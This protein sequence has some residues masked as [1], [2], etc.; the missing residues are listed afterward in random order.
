MVETA[1]RRILITGG[2]GALGSVSARVLADAGA[3]VAV[4]DVL[5]PDE[6][7]ARVGDPR[8]AYIEADSST[9]KGVATLVEAT[10]GALGTPT[11]VVLMAAV[12][13]PGGLLDQTAEDIEATLRVNVTAALLTA[14]A[15]VRQWV[16]LGVTGNLVFVSSWVQDVP[17]PGIAPYSASKAAL[18]SVARSFARE[19]AAK[20]IRANILAP[21]IVGTGMAKHQW[22]T[23]PDYRRRAARAIP[24][25]S[26]Q[27]P[28]SVADALVFLCSPMSSYMTGSTLLIDGGASLYPLDPDEVADGPAD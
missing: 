14:Q 27:T 26:L 18:R 22:D 23:E 28:Q 24:L 8:V 16:D 11:D 1:G 20:G 12:V 4:S 5:A 15:F 3:R 19:F 7:Q 21:G 10:A 13:R 2:A 9:A 6:A 25:G 17:W